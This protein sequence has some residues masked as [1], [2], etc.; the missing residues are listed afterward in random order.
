MA[1]DTDLALSSGQN[2]LPAN[3]SRYLETI[4]TQDRD[5]IFAKAAL[6]MMGMD[7]MGATDS[8]ASWKMA[9]AAL[10]AET[11]ARGLEA[12]GM[13][14]EAARMA[15]EM[16][17]ASLANRM[18]QLTDMINIKVIQT[19]DQ[20]TEAVDYRTL[21]ENLEILGAKAGDA[22]LGRPFSWNPALLPPGKK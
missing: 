6:G 22:L 17:F 3:A 20:A 13:M 10:A 8:Y 4:L 21:G 18:N 5:R 1:R 12:S 19:V 2:Y 16:R 15:Q 11:A 9:Q 7:T 14:T